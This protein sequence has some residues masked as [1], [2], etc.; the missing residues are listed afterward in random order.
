MVR[1]CQLI[2]PHLTEGV[3]S[4]TEVVQPRK[5]LKWCYLQPWDGSRYELNAIY[6]KVKRTHIAESKRRNKQHAPFG[7]EMRFAIGSQ[8]LWCRGSQPKHVSNPDSVIKKFK[9]HF[10]HD[11]LNLFLKYV[12]SKFESSYIYS[13]PGSSAKV[14]F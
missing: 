14:P 6:A 4:H 2:T 9:P 11:F 12:G 1:S 8:H 7:F 3:I 13:W 5:M 10:I